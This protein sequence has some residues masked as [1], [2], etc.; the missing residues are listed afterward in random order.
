[1]LLGMLIAD[2]RI[3]APPLDV[4]SWLLWI[5]AEDPGDELQNLI[6]EN[7]KME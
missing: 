1:M 7:P 6:A 4:G 2:L 3:G 5:E